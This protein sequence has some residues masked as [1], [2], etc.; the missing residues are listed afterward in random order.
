MGLECLGD[1]YLLASNVTRGTVCEV[2]L[3]A[4]VC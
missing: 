3:A 4:T 1:V 2:K